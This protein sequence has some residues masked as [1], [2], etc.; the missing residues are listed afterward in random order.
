[1]RAIDGQGEALAEDEVNDL[2]NV[3][4]RNAGWHDDE[5]YEWVR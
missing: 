5:S 1:M 3:D 4:E 2:L